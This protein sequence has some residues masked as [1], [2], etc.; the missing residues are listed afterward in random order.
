M[1][2]LVD[3]ALPVGSLRV[4]KQPCLTVDDHLV[5]RP[6]H[7]DDAPAV[8]GA[9]AQPDIQRWHVRRIDSEAE[10][11][12]WIGGWSRHWDRESDASWAIARTDDHAIGQ[13]GLRTI[14][15]FA[16]QA[17]MSYWVLPDA[18][19]ARVAARA[20]RALTQWAFD[21]LGLHRLF[22]MHS[23]ANPASCRVALNAGFQPEGTMRGYTLHT[24]GWHDMHMH[25]RLR[26][27]VAD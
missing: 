22:L 4:L 13:V 12:D 25:G 9:F 16:A 3:P 19:G 7:S 8:M 1:P 5:L 18:R 14:M 23:T 17:Q 27:D 26:T 10:A 20:T 11:R 6:W 21:T 2:L 24:D 15:L